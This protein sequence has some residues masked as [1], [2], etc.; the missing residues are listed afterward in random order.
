MQVWLSWATPSTEARSIG[1]S[2][3]IS[4]ADNK[5]FLTRMWLYQESHRITSR[6]KKDPFGSLLTIP[7]ATLNDLLQYESILPCEIFRS[8]WQP[9]VCWYQLGLFCCPAGAACASVTGKVHLPLAY[10]ELGELSQA[11]ASLPAG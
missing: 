5:M 8:G 2:E 3:T 6:W 10:A 4:N 7:P 11:P 1:V 9:P